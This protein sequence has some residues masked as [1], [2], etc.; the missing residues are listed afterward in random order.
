LNV[1]VRKYVPGVKLIG[2][3]LFGKS[4]T[5]WLLDELAVGNVIEP[6]VTAGE[7]PK[8]WPLMVRVLLG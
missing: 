3:V 2:G 8:F 4:A 6:N 7:L 5:T 1:T